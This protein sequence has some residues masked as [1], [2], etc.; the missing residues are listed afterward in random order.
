MDTI[1]EIRRTEATIAR[2]NLTFHGLLLNSLP[3]LRL[4]ALA[5]TRHR[6]DAEYL[7]HSAVVSAL[8]A[9]SSFELGTNFRAWMT[10]IIRN[11]F[12]LIFAAV[13]KL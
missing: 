5:L 9:E 3:S 10:R 1:C 11:R 6:A 2:E 4:H 12:F 13:V 8:A 7:L